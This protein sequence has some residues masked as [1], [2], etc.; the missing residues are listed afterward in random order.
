[1]YVCICKGITDTQIRDAVDN[2]VSSFRELR[3]QL[4]LA[5]SCG[6]CGTMAREIFDEHLGN[7]NPDLCYAVA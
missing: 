7:Y 5:S 4:E 2:G 6:K 3:Q 1:M